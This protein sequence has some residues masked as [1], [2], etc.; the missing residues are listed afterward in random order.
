M[1]LENDIRGCLSPF[2]GNMLTLFASKCDPSNYIVN[3]GCYK[4]KSLDYII[5]GIRSKFIQCSTKRVIGID[6]KLCEDLQEI[7]SVRQETTFI[8]GSSYSRNVLNKVPNN[9][10]LVFIDGDH[11]YDGCMMDLENYWS[12]LIVGGILM[13][14]DVF[15]TSGQQCE[16]EV[17]K[18]FMDFASNH[19]NEFVPDDW[20][21]GPIHR[22]DSSA[23]VWKK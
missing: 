7:I 16:P 23:I 13:V 6:I 19:T 20:Y 18:A 1:K 4:G 11:S 14:H 2:E 12:K 10:E 9:L 21:C 3:I 15:D 8:S 17:N 5:T 22:V